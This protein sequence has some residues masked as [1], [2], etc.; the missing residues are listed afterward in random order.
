MSHLDLTKLDMTRR[1]PF[2]IIDERAWRYILSNLDEVRRP[3]AEKNERAVKTL[4]SI[5]YIPAQLKHTEKYGLPEF[6]GGLVM[7]R[8][9]HHEVD[10]FLL[11]VDKLPDKIVSRKP[12]ERLKQE[13]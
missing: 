12:L 2:E 4:V 5:G 8:I 11:S 10:I 6:V 13:G 9:R 1:A 7:F 3:I